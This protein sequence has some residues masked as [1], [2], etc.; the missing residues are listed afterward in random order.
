MICSG[1][2]LQ[3]N[4]DEDIYGGGNSMRVTKR[5]PNIHRNWARNEE[6]E[7]KREK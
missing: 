6:R 5:K 2:T 3:Q 1:A 7:R 4:H